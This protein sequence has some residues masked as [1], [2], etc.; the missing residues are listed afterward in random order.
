MMKLIAAFQNFANKS[1]NG[2]PSTVQHYKVLMRVSNIYIQ[3]PS[4]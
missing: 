1:K 3:S 2:K 4:L